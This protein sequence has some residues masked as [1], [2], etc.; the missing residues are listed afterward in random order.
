MK[1]IYESESLSVFILFK[2]KKTS[3][4]FWI[5]GCNPITNASNLQNVCFNL[6]I[7]FLVHD[8]KKNFFFFFYIQGVM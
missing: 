5:L 4:Y 3:Q 2:F 6:G 7:V 8:D 1:V